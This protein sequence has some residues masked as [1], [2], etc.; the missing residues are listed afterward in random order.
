[1][2]VNGFDELSIAMNKHPI[3]LKAQELKGVT[4]YCWRPPLQN[5]AGKVISVSYFAGVI[6]HWNVEESKLGS[7]RAAPWVDS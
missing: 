7:T 2:E 5:K 3:R 6:E 4:S 1:L